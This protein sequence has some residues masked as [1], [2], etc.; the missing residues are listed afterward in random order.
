[1]KKTQLAMEVINLVRKKLSQKM[2]YL[3]PIIYYLTPLF[4]E[5]RDPMSTDGFY[6]FINPDIILRS[7]KS[8]PKKLMLNYLHILSHCILGHIHKRQGSYTEIFDCVADCIT[9]QFI[10]RASFGLID[11]E[12]TKSINSCK[13]LS[14]L[15][16]QKGLTGVYEYLL[17]NHEELKEFMKLIG[18][19]E[20]DVHIYWNR[21][22]PAIVKMNKDK[23]EKGN[24][25]AWSQWLAQ[26][27]NDI[28][29]HW[30]ELM[31]ISQEMAKA[32]GESNL[33]GSITGDMSKLIS[34]AED[35]EISYRDFLLGFMEEKEATHIDPDSIDYLWYVTGLGLYG[36][37]PLIEPL[38]YRE[39]ATMD[40]IIIA[41]D[42]SGSCY[43]TMN[44]FLRET[45]NILKEVDFNDRVNIRI[46][47]CDSG[48][49][50][51]WIINEEADL[52]DFNSGIQIKGFGGT[53]FRPVFSHINKLIEQGEIDKVRVLL[54]FTD[55]FG[56]FPK[57]APEYE[58]VIILPNE[59]VDPDI[60][61][62]ITRIKLSAKDF[63][64]M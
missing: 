58:T 31:S 47:Q 17:S 21:P 12:G 27:H 26:Y 51:D 7:F 8:N 60:P 24:T 9:V 38:E 28:E 2:N 36:N 37:T 44:V 14:S 45:Y 56:D 63:I 59:D 25:Q 1:M 50:D 52:P 13:W 19:I 41:L 43:D 6:L 10:N 29:A 57:K 42:T 4:V 5:E 23:I 62:W 39:E 40:N 54:Y 32:R 48:I 22:H 46:I 55:G 53:D 64:L 15:M 49:C 35:N 20:R 3:T 30:S 11:S 18:F 34:K 33:W 61:D 16:E